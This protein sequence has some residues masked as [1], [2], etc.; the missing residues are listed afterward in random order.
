MSGRNG[1]KAVGIM[2]AAGL[3]RRLGRPKLGL[4]VAGR[5]LLRWAV[6]HCLAGGL[7]ELIVVVGP[8]E[9][10]RPL[11]PESPRLRLKVNPRPEAGQS[12]SL[13][14]GLAGLPPGTAWAA[15]YLGDM[16]CIWPEI[17]RT[18]LARLPET[19]AS[20][21]RPGFASRP[22]HPV[23]FQARWFDQLRA[24]DGDQGGR[25]VLAAHPEA[26]EIVTF[27]QAEP[28]LDVDTEADLSAAEEALRARAAR[29]E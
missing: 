27:D 4:M 7:T 19:A 17:T 24:L 25:E 15:V 10:P 9:D 5:P 29:R 26:I 2:L 3:S 18:L 1:A 16:P 13:A 21:V 11:L 12:G 6:D 23:I 28:L 8:R 14:I 22:G 20:I